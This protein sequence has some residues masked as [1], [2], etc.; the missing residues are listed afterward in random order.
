MLE[1][2]YVI[3]KGDVD[4]E[5][6]TLCSVWWNLDDA[7][8]AASDT[9]KSIAKQSSNYPGQYTVQLTTPRESEVLFT[10]VRNATDRST[11]RET[12]WWRVS[13]FEVRGSDIR[14]PNDP[15]L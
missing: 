1:H 2:V 7:L 11:S 8:V 14:D 3:Q 15:A 6:E 13:R 12:D 4:H 9:A 10:L 5:N